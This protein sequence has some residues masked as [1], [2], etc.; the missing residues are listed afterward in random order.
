MTN[1][2]AGPARVKL[3]VA[4]AILY[5]VWG[6]TYL[7]IRFAI[8]TM[9]PIWMA[10]M[11]FVI[12]GAILFLFTQSRHSTR[13]TKRQWFHAL[14]IGALMFGGG[15][16]L[17]SWSEQYVPSGV[18]ALIIATVPLWMALLDTILFRAARPNLRVAA[19]L[20]LGM[21]G[22]V[23]L[24]D[25]AAAS[26]GSVSPLGAAMLL[27]ACLCWSYASLRS[28]TLD[29]PSSLFITA[30]M[31]MLCGGVVLMACST[32]MGDW[33]RIHL[34]AIS[35]K[36]LAAL[37]YLIVFGSMLALSAFTWLLRNCPA[38]TVA[39]YAYVNPV[40]AMVLGAW[41]GGETLSIRTGVAAGL[42]VAS[43]VVIVTQRNRVS[44]SPVTGTSSASMPEEPPAG[45]DAADPHVAARETC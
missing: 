3:I 20:L 42:I 31:Q 23:L 21:I 25:P 44:N 35:F 19:G 27:T 4:F 30:G 39:T 11:R 16:G 8:E 41:L 24:V 14:W 33:T 36:S 12:A 1:R 7:A 22:V 45:Y 28:R 43:V 40:I 26:A 5:F 32:L 6:S 17:V 18:T 34:D 2:A 10:G 37:G 15:N 9:P 29:L 38:A 13:P